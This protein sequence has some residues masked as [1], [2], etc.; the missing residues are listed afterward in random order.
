M[1]TQKDLF[2]K[3]IYLDP[4]FISFKYEEIK[5]VSPT[6]QFSKAEGMKADGGIPLL[7][8][9][10]YSQETRTYILSSRQMLKEISNEL[11]DYPKFD[12]QNFAN[13]QKTRTSWIDG[14]F[15]TSEIISQK[16]SEKPTYAFFMITSGDEKYSLL[17]QPENFNS[18]ISALLTAHYILRYDIS[19]PVKALV[20]VMYRVEC[21]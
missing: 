19:I 17:A 20:R 16:E 13:G 6:T 18:N 1:T 21:E 9:G 3:L 11:E 14:F 8:A 4:D 15:T 12:S 7:K 2:D 10:I 5:Q